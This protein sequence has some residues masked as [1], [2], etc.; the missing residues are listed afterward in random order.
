MTSLAPRPV[1]SSRRRQKGRKAP[2]VAAIGAPTTIAP[3]LPDNRRWLAP[4]RAAKAAATTPWTPLRVGKA[5]LL[6]AVCAGSAF[7]VVRARVFLERSTDWVVH[8]VD[9][10]GFSESDPR[11]GEVL[12]Y[13]N[14]ADGS[15]FFAIQ[16]A[17]V[18][19]RVARHPFV[20]SVEVH[21]VLPDAISISVTPR[22]P[23]AVLRTD[24]GLFLVD[25]DGGFIKRVRP[26]DSL[27]LPLI[28]LQNAPTE[29]SV[30]TAPTPSPEQHF[31]PRVVDALAVVRAAEEAGLLG[32]LSEV[33]ELP[34]VGFEVVLLDGSRARLGH[35]LFVPK[36][37]RLLAAEQELLASG[38]RFSFVYLDD[39]RH[40]ERVSVRL[41][42]ATETAP[43]GGG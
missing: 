21:R 30:K 6:V 43:V 3:A 29:F 36:L 9:V 26:S 40:P 4:L 23:R 11:V 24:V 35:D 13:A 15:P 22:I 20:E 7:G 1:S 37:R 16:P 32:R 10:D 19:E 18:A 33:V 28:A 25:D 5:C 42:P 31:L 38:R 39:A 2:F 17:V 14:V 41:R 34:A 12:T 27:D 8:S